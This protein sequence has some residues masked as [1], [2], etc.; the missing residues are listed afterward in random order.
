[1]GVAVAWLMLSEVGRLWQWR[2]GQGVGGC[3]RHGTECFVVE[4]ISMCKQQQQ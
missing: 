1:M 4:L 2:R 3:G